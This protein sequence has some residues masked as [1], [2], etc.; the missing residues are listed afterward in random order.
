MT[1]EEETLQK[2]RELFLQFDMREMLEE[3]YWSQV[4]FPFCRATPRSLDLLESEDAEE[5][6]DQ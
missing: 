2:I 5:P 6:Q 1:S 3:F 4:E